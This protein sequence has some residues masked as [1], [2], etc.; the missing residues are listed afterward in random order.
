MTTV[1]YGHS[2]QSVELNF[3]CNGWALFSMFLDIWCCKLCFWLS[4][5]RPGVHWD[6]LYGS[7][8]NLLFCKLYNAAKNFGVTEFVNPNDHDK[9]IQQVIV[10]LTDGGVDYSFECIGNVKVMRAALECCHKVPFHSLYWLWVKS[11]SMSSRNNATSTHFLCLTC[12]GGE[13]LLLWVLQPQVR[14]FLLVLS[15]WWLAVFGRGQPLVVSRADLRCHGSLKSTWKRWITYPCVTLT[16]H[17]FHQSMHHW[18]LAFEYHLQLALHFFPC[19]NWYQRFILRGTG[20][21][22][23]LI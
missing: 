12:R 21:G 17:Y 6:H 10:D 22:K 14:R 13:H 19:L 1:L 18:H 9:P 11:M 5:L 15:N 7:Q 20:H 23:W 8:I 2:V 4:H 16:F 3:L